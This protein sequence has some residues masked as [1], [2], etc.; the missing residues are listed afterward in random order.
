MSKF[1]CVCNLSFHSSKKIMFLWFGNHLH[2]KSYL[3]SGGPWL[4][5]WLLWQLRQKLSSSK[6]HHS[7]LCLCG[8]MAV[9]PLY[10]FAASYKDTV[11][12]KG[13][14]LLVA[15]IFYFQIGHSWT[16][17]LHS[18]NTVQPIAGNDSFPFI[19]P[20]WPDALHRP[21]PWPLCLLIIELQSFSQSSISWPSKSR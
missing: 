20:L 8:Y 18:R 5:F 11:T 13:F 21:I 6:P 9:F 15:F 14:I 3:E 10:V 4:S 7:N 2:I 17:T 19:P 12:L 1:V 16:R